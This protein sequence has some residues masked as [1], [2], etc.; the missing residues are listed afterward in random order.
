MIEEQMSRGRQKDMC[1][2]SWYTIVC[3]FSL[4]VLGGLL[5][6]AAQIEMNRNRIAREYVTNRGRIVHGRSRVPGQIELGNS[7]SYRTGETDSN[8]EIMTQ[9]GDVEIKTKNNSSGEIVVDIDPGGNWTDRMTEDGLN[10]RHRHKRGLMTLVGKEAFDA[11]GGFG[12]IR[13]FVFELVLPII[14]SFGKKRNTE[15]LK[16]FSRR[17]IPQ[18][19]LKSHES[20]GLIKQQLSVGHYNEAI[21]T[22]ARQRV[23]VDVQALSALPKD[24]YYG[25]TGFQDEAE[26]YEECQKLLPV[27]DSLIQER[28][29]SQTTVTTALMQSLYS[30]IKFHIGEQID[31]AENYLEGLK[32]ETGLVEDMLDDLIMEHL[33]ERVAI[34]AIQSVTFLVCLICVWALKHSLSQQ[35]QLCNELAERIEVVLHQGRGVSRSDSDRKANLLNY[36]TPRFQTPEMS[37]AIVART[38]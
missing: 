30:D 13:N 36:D 32:Q 29:A 35:R 8:S 11:I 1:H 23:R 17:L 2:L 4:S 14:K 27:V 33:Y 3:V 34:I 21:D 10:T 9:Y 26:V 37:R 16:G 15:V 5:I 31:L 25:S 12:G 24:G 28:V 7:L 18:T 20:A 38:K 19:G 6:T 22:M